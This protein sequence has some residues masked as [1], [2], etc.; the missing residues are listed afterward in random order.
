M[1]WSG[2]ENRERDHDCRVAVTFSED[3][4]RHGR[5]TITWSITIETECK[6]PGWTS[7]NEVEQQHITKQFHVPLTGEMRMSGQCIH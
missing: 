6:D 2:L 3:K 1:D 7:W 5:P 4:R